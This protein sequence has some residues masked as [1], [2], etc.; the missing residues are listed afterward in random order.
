MIALTL[1]ALLQKR[2]YEVATAFSGKEAV[3]KA[4]EFFPDLLLSDVNMEAKNG[5]RAVAQITANLPDCKVLLF[6]RPRLNGRNIDCCPLSAS[7][8]GTV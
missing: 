8:V 6:V 5:L 2:G 3:A 7:C 4:A 1:S